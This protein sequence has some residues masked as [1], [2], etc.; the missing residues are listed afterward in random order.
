MPVATKVKFQDLEAT[1]PIS[2]P[3]A[4][5]HTYLLI[6]YD[7]Y[8]DDHLYKVNRTDLTVGDAM[9]ND[10]FHTWC[11]EWFVDLSTITGNLQ[12]ARDE[13]F[14]LNDYNDVWT[15]AP[16]NLPALTKRWFEIMDDERWYI[17]ELKK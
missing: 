1:P 14:V 11:D 10:L 12:V 4:T 16:Y 6:W 7:H 2:N 8:K 13:A 17:A 9:D 15:K 5:T 3:D